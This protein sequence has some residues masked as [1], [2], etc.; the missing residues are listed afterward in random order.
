LENHFSDYSANRQAQ[1]LPF[2][3]CSSTQYP[4]LNRAT[5]DKSPGKRNRPMSQAL[6]MLP[7]AFTMLALSGVANA[8]TI[9]NTIGTGAS[10][11][12]GQNATSQS[13]FVGLD[14]N[15]TAP[16]TPRTPQTAG[17][18]AQP[19]TLNSLPGSALKGRVNDV[20]IVMNIK[21]VVGMTTS[22]LDRLYGAFFIPG[23]DPTSG[24]P[25]LAASSQVGSFFQFDTS[26]VINPIEPGEGDNRVRIY[27]AP[28]VFNAS[29]FLDI[30]TNY[31]LA[32]APADGLDAPNNAPLLMYGLHLFRTPG[33]IGGANGGAIAN[34]FSVLGSAQ[35]ETG[36]AQPG[37]VLTQR[38]GAYFGV[39]VGVA[40]PEPSSALLLI[41]A[42]LPTGA[43]LWRRRRK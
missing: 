12:L 7:A 9:I 42:A 4:Y 18:T 30:G 13:H 19:F 15:A 24:L 1:Y 17:Y 16:A 37:S 6:R 28:N 36:G 40:V 38:N 11:S 20:S 33:Q 27:S 32:I 29:A 39:R 22:N 23:N 5:E 14:P 41:G 34:A 25:S 10:Y 2:V 8:Q 35:F 3:V 21:S 43:F 31:L 26:A